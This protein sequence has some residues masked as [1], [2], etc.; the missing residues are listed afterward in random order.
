[1]ELPHKLYEEAFMKNVIKIL[2]VIIGSLIGAGF[3]SRKRNL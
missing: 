3:A 1:M 2:F